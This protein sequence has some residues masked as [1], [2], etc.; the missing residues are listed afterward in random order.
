MKFFSEK[1]FN[2]VMPPM[3]VR[4]ELL[5]GTGHLPGDTEDY[6][7]T[8]DGDALIGTAEVSLMGYYKDEILD[9]KDLPVKFLGFSACFR[10]E[11]GSYSK[12]VKGLIR[13]HEFYKFEQ[14]IL[15]EASHE[16]SVKYHEEL[17]R[18]TE[19]FIE[20]L[21]IPYHTVIN[22]GGDLGQGQVKKYDIEL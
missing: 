4:K 16:L 21:N 14:F 7:L 15:C 9:I 20:S 11:A 1:G 17:H 13:V 18:N 3:I 19:E 5:Y 10:R 12:D 6:Y 2:P 8:Q 22:A